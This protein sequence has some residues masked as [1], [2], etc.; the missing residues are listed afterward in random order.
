VDFDY[1]IV[2]AGAAGCVLASRLSEDPGNQVLLLEYGGRDANPLL[3]VPEGFYFTLRGN[4]Y[5]YHYPTRPIGPGGQVE[6][7]L[8]GKVLGGSTAVNGM[9]WTRGAAADWDGLAARGNPAFGWERVL[10]AYRA[11]EDHNLGASDMRGAGGPLGVSVVENHDELVQAVLASAQ[12]MG[13]EHVADTNA[14]DSERVGFTPSTI[15]HGVRTSAYSAFVRPVSDRPNLTV[16]TRTLAGYLL[17][18][19][20]RVAGVRAANGVRT[21]DYRARKEVILSAGTVETP[22]LLPHQD[23]AWKII[24]ERLDAL[25][26]ACASLSQQAGLS[27]L[28]PLTEQLQSM[29]QD[30]AAHASRTASRR[31]RQHAVPDRR[32]P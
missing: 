3:Y 14:H 29:S 26:Q 30:I 19:G 2:G 21:A 16:A 24:N 27:A 5:A 1:I 15:R 22:L 20:E 31:Q 13:W 10:A 7:W 8:R 28:A 12:D 11:M 9:M 6:A 4:R 18:D 25:A 23:A 32:E 17:F